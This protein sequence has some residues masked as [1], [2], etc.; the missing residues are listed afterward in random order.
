MY[1]PILLASFGSIAAKVVVVAIIKVS[2]AL[3]LFGHHTCI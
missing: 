1:E 2:P 3:Y